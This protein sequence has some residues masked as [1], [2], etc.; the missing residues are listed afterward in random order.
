MITTYQNPPV[1]IS[2]PVELPFQQK[3]IKSNGMIK[4]SPLHTHPFGDPTPSR[5]DIVMTQN[6]IEIARPLGM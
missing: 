1:P 2:R 3:A 4:N 6:L 5:A